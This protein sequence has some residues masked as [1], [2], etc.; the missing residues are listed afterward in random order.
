LVELHAD[1]PLSVTVRAERGV[2]VLH[3]MNVGRMEMHIVNE[4]QE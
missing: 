4:D 3:V 2:T 1:M